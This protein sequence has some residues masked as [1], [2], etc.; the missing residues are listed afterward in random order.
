MG[1]CGLAVCLWQM[2]YVTSTALIKCSIIWTLIR[3]SKRR[4][5]PYP[6]HALFTVSAILGTV[7]FFAALFRCKPVSAAWTGE[8]TCIS[9]KVTIGFSYDISALNIVIDLATAIIQIFLSW[10]MQMKKNLKILTY[11][12]LGLGIL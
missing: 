7:S 1:Q 9:Q 6:L 12:I 8:G 5:Y 4:R 11:M 2:T 3:L 10:H